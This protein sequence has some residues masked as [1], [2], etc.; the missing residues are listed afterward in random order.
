MPFSY[1]PVRFY[2]LGVMAGAS[3][4]ASLGLTYILAEWID[5]PPRLAFAITLLVVF[6]GNFLA[7]RHWA[8]RERLQGSNP[9]RQL[10]YFT[11]VSL[12]SRTVEWIGFAVFST[13]LT[14]DYMLTL[15]IVLM[16]SFVFKAFI[17]DR[18]VFR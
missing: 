7:A 1:I 3:F 6:A 9:Q 8:F 2:K 5:L 16:L 14:W 15:V 11:V 13:I 10:L 18:F 17:F 12:I 4:S